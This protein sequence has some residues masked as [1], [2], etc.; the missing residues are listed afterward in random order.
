MKGWLVGAIIGVLAGFFV[1]GVGI[2]VRGSATSVPSWAI[3][4]ILAFL[5]AMTGNYVGKIIPRRKR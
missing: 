5:G 2:A 1:G 3:V 4:V